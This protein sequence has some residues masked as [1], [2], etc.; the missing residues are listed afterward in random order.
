MD[1]NEEIPQEN[2][3]N[4]YR[5]II[6][7]MCIFVIGFVFIVTKIKILGWILVGFGVG[8]IINDFLSLIRR[9]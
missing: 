4:K 6:I 3:V 9:E 5:Y 1:S 8:I 7:G 2:V